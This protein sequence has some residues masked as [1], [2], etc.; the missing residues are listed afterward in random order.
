MDRARQLERPAGRRAGDRDRQ[1]LRP[2]EHGD[3][4][5]GLRA[6]TAR[7]AREDRVY[8]GFLQT[9]A[10]I[11]PGNSG[12]PLLNAEGALIGINTAVYQGAQGIG[13]A[14]PIDVA[15]RVVSELLTQGEVSPVWLGVD[16]QDLDGRIA[17]LMELPRRL[18][19]ALVSR[20]REDGPA[21]RRRHRARRRDRA[22]RRRAGADARASST[23]T[24]SARP[25]GQTPRARAAG[26]RAPSAASRHR[27]G[28]SAEPQIDELGEQLLG[29]R[30]G[31]ARTRPAPL[32]E[33]VRA[34]S[35]AAQIGL[36]AGD[37]V[38]GI[39]GRGLDEPGGLAARRA[40]PAGPQPRA[41][42][43]SARARSIP[44]DGSALL[45]AAA[46]RRNPP[47]AGGVSER[48]SRR[49]AGEG[50]HGSLLEVD[51]LPSVLAR[52]AARAPPAWW[53]CG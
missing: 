44:C 22:H 34:G 10:S 9:D 11:N 2:L 37:R 5:R 35:G 31:R 19:G 8:H 3:D 27:A 39:N 38:L 25:P 20:V 16:V 51:R 29:V 26:A 50:F 13:F 48:S 21:A 41:R 46:P 12:G 53:T 36:Q 33:A 32:V 43:G 47:H 7:C 14:I 24:S 17:E 42:R 18:A 45:S 30:L 52:G 1:P 49:Q 23:S 15:K 28:H 4:R 40:R 6:R